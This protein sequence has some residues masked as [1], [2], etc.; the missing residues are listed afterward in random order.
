M[1]ATLGNGAVTFGDGSSQST[2]ANVFN[3]GGTYSINIT[4]SSG[5][6][7][8]INSGGG[9]QNMTV[10]NIGS[11]QLAVYVNNTGTHNWNDSISGGSISTQYNAFWAQG[12]NTGYYAYNTTSLPGTWRWLGGSGALSFVR[13]A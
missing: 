8:S 5:S 3:N 1:S 4:G 7:G 9:L 12:Y 11:Y 2:A 6:A 10:N 13:I